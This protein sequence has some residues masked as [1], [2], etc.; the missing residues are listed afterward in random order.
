MTHFVSYLAIKNRHPYSDFLKN[1]ND[2]AVA[3]SVRHV[4]HRRAGPRAISAFWD[5]DGAG[6]Y[7]WGPERRK[8]PRLVQPQ[9]A[10]TDYIHHEAD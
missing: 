9:V 1:F 5:R 2:I 4:Q 3:L 10:S 7:P 6:P 8:N